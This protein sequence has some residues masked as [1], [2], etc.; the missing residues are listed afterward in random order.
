MAILFFLIFREIDDVNFGNGGELNTSIIFYDRFLWA[1]VETTNQVTIHES[2]YTFTCPEEGCGVDSSCSLTALENKCEGG[3]V[4]GR[5]FSTEDG[6]VV[7]SL[8]QSKASAW[9]EDLGP[10]GRVHLLLEIFELAALS[11]AMERERGLD[12]FLCSQLI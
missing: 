6:P 2:S 8:I 3:W 7:S 11:M 10:A 9:A 5:P 12:W 1:W 4:M